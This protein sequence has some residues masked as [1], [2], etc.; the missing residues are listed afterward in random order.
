MC[1]RATPEMRLR[2]RRRLLARTFLGRF[3]FIKKQPL[4][5]APNERK[6]ENTSVQYSA[7]AFRAAELKVTIP[8]LYKIMKNS[9]N[10][11]IL[12]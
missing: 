3:A 12:F 1:K 8:T 5:S 11:W 6:R 10:K 9:I 4:R 7:I 2:R